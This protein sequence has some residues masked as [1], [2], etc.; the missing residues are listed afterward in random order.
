MGDE[1]DDDLH[2]LELADQEG[3]RSGQGQAGREVAGGSSLT[4]PEA[5]V[6]VEDDAT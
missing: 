5:T 6:R 4:P 3:R 1:R 2:H